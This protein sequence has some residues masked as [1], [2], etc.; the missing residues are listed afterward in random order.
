MA[1]A[2]FTRSSGDTSICTPH[3]RNP[4][5][6]LE[7][8]LGKRFQE[9]AHLYPLD[10]QPIRP[11]RRRV[12][13]RLIGCRIWNAR[14]SMGGAKLRQRDD[15]LHAVDRLSQRR[16]PGIGAFGP[17]HDAGNVTA[18]YDKEFH[19][20]QPGKH[21][22]GDR[23]PTRRG[24]R[25]SRARLRLYGPKVMAARDRRI[26]GMPPFAKPEDESYRFYDLGLAYEVRP[27]PPRP[28]ATNG[29]AW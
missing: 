4:V 23:S 12:G 28:G 6:S 24:R 25:T 18:S 19:C 16:V 26:E 2:T 15:Q 27:T 1:P 5:L 21:D 29:Q 9:P 11:G 13:S 17:V 8:Y 7:A 22:E 14:G 3:Y 10:A 20:V